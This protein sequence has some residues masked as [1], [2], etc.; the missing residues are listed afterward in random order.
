MEDYLPLPSADP[1]IQPSNPLVYTLL[2]HLD[3]L[4]ALLRRFCTISGLSA[5]FLRLTW[6]SFV[7]IRQLDLRI[8]PN[9]FQGRFI[10]DF[11]ICRG[12][13]SILS[14]G[15]F[16]YVFQQ[17]TSKTLHQLQSDCKDTSKCPQ[18]SPKS[19][20]GVFQEAP[21][22][23][24]ESSWDILA[25]PGAVRDFQRI[26][27]RF[28]NPSK[29]HE[30]YHHLLSLGLLLSALLAL[31]GVLRPLFAPHGSSLAALGPWLGDLWRPRR[32]AGVI[33]ANILS[34]PIE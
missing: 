4:G 7:K 17:I 14:Y 12:L 16:P 9:I 10:I 19:L 15:V 21:R 23:L 3:A 30:M 2:P 25:H 26:Y 1:R 8:G 31:L 33:L 29:T 20:P 32:A 5:S 11:L 28:R 6:R 27:N 18:N 22:P 13:I 34:N 24:Q